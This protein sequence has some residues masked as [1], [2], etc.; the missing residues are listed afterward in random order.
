M[1]KKNASQLKTCIYC[2]EKKI[3]SREHVMPASLGGN[4][5]IRCVCEGCN[6][7]LSDLDQSLSDS[8]LLSLIRLTKHPG[9]SLGLSKIRI[10]SPKDGEVLEGSLE[11]QLIPSIRPQI[12]F[13]KKDDAYLIKAFGG[14][15]EGFEKLFK[16]I[17]KYI[18]KNKLNEIKILSPLSSIVSGPSIVMHRSK[19][20]AFRPSSTEADSGSE[21]KEITQF[22]AD[23]I[24]ELEFII[25]QKLEKHS[26][27]EMEKPALEVSMG[28]QFGLNLRAVSKIALN[29]LAY[30]CGEEFVLGDQFNPLRNYI[31]FG[32]GQNLE[33]AIW[34]PGTAEEPNI[35]SSRYAT[36]IHN[37]DGGPRFPLFGNPNTHAIYILYSLDRY[38][39]FIEFYNWTVYAVDL[40]TIDV[41]HLA[42]PVVHE[43][44]YINKLNRKVSVAEV[45][46]GFN[47]I[48]IRY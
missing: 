32:D 7:G 4:L 29:Y 25:F 18:L 16:L 5:I 44:D 41:G 6:G 3:S 2:L 48:P 35:A 33:G 40:G 28:F 42:F 24:K 30:C 8:S 31:R 20:I 21:R 39:L 23:K 43:F 36:W 11:H 26:S 13:Y 10:N 38:L 1:E 14:T 15:T 27:T 17:R 46:R 22:I 37:H 19:D 9:T 45:V 12:N 47:S 34:N